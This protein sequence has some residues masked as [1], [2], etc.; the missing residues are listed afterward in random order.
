MSLGILSVEVKGF[1]NLTAL[2]PNEGV[3]SAASAQLGLIKTKHHVVNARQHMDVYTKTAMQ[4]CSITYN[5]CQLSAVY[6]SKRIYGY[7]TIRQQTFY[8]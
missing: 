7:C 4:P 8:I 3:L 6:F 2:I 1:D 5:S